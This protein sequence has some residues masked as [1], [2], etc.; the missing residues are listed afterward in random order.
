MSGSNPLGEGDD[1]G[2]PGEIGK[3]VGVTLVHMG[4]LFWCWACRCRW[5]TGRCGCRWGTGNSRSLLAHSS[6]AS[7]TGGDLLG[8]CPLVLCSCPLKPPS[9][10]PPLQAGT[11]ASSRMWVSLGRSP[12]HDCPAAGSGTKAPQPWGLPSPTE[13]TRRRDK[14][15]P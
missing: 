8:V 2:R 13:V 4:H 3:D 11:A 14:L 10:P 15:C 5:R 1:G 9:H 7:C 12:A 6:Y